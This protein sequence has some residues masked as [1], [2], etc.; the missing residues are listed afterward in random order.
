METPLNERKDY[1]DFGSLVDCF[2]TDPS[3]FSKTYYTFEGKKPT[4]N[5]GVRQVL[6]TLASLP[7]PVY[8]LDECHDA[9]VEISAAVSYGQSYKPET[10]LKKVKE[11][12]DYYRS[13]IDGKGKVEVTAEMVANARYSADNLQ[14]GEYTKTFFENSG[15]F[16]YFPK[17]IRT[18]EYKSILCKA[19]IDGVSI[20]LENKV[21]R[22]FDVKTTAD[23][24]LHF[25]KN[26][27]KYRY[28][29]QGSFYLL[30]MADWVEAKAKEL[31]WND[32][33]TDFYFLVASSQERDRL[34]I[35]YKLSNESI[36]IGMFG[37]IPEKRSYNY[38]GIKQAFERLHWHTVASSWDYP[39]EFYENN[40][41]P[42]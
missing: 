35:P 16:Q 14:Y 33:Q 2:L 5:S 11:Y 36:T 7:E 20:D 42:I 15:K 41:L 22:I 38:E 17:V 18:F 4:E 24:P 1:F 28:D 13:L 8:D 26:F 25:S 31:G 37:G 34:P 39:L 23:S 3:A 9:I 32:Y 6:D 19:E 29:F 30:A 40:F 12:D 21:I 27:W 10:L